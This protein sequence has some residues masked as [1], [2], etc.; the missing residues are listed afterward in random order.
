MASLRKKYQPQ[1]ENRSDDDGPPVQSPPV[2]GAKMPEAVEP[3]PV[4]PMVESSPAEEAAKTALKSRLA[5]MERAAQLS[6]QRQQQQP[7]HASEP[8]QQQPAMPAHVQEW[9]SRHPEY[10]DPHNRIAQ[11]EINLATEKC[12]RDG[13]TWNDDDFL[14]SIERHLGIAPRT[15]G[16]VESKPTASAP[17]QRP[18]TADRPAVRPSAPPV[19]APPTR[20]VPSY[21]TGR[22]PR[23]RA[24]LTRDEL[25]IAAASGQTPEQY[26]AQKD[27]MLRMKESGQLQ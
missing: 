17:P 11:L 20:E 22:A 23:H 25:E 8:Q 26:Q 1:F 14:P 2:T 9:L 12:V 21:S 10:T 13:L 27:K 15:N 5:E 16:Q 18:M 4:E 24:P 6:E 3:K 19:S 7:Q